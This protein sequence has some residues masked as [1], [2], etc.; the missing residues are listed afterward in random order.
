MCRRLHHVP[1]CVFMCRDKNLTTVN[2]L[3]WCLWQ[4]QTARHRYYHSAFNIFGRGLFVLCSCSR[5]PTS[6]P[7]RLQTHQG[8]SQLA[9][10]R[11]VVGAKHARSEEGSGSAGARLEKNGHGQRTD[12]VFCKCQVGAKRTRSENGL[13]FTSARSEKP[14]ALVRAHL[15]V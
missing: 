6:E 4:R 7:N 15:S 11:T 3:I 13:V 5:K 14:P 10:K 8:R 9:H 1:L 2:F 12:W